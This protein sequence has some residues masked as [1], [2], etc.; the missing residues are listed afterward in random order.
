MGQADDVGLPPPTQPHPGWN[1]RCARD[2]AVRGQRPSAVRV[3]PDRGEWR[4]F[5]ERSAGTT[6]AA[7]PG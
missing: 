3:G 1:R 6:R 4:W 5:A 2:T 7:A